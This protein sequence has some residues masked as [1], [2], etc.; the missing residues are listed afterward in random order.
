MSKF[1]RRRSKL[2]GKATVAGEL[3][4]LGMYPGFKAG[5]SGRVTGELYKLDDK[6]ASETIEMLDAYEGVTGEKED[7][8]LRKEVE[9]RVTDGGKFTAMTYISRSIPASAKQITK[10]NY[11][12]FYAGNSNHQ[13]FVNGG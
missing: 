2:V 13:K 9:C 6:R 3:Y 1:L 8:Y 5:G 10:G 11:A 7:E 4:D 12:S